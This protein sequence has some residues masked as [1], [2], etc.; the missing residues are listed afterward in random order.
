MEGDFDVQRL[1]GKSSNSDP[2][3]AMMVTLSIAGISA[4][5]ALTSST[6]TRPAFVSDRRRP[7]IGAPFS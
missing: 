2:F 4:M 5:L 1:I 7:R 3:G 6:S